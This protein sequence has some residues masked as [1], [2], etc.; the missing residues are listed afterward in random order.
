MPT[1]LLATE[2][3]KLAAELPTKLLATELAELAAELLAT[4]L[5]KLAAELLPAELLATKLTKL[6]T[7]LLPTELLATELLATTLLTH[8]GPNA[9]LSIRQTWCSRGTGTSGT[10]WHHLAIR[11]R[12]GFTRQG[13]HHNNRHQGQGIRRL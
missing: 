2:L 6:P 3:T 11:L 4:E 1:K 9:C 10:A 5:A 8:V 13:E 7:E 12:R